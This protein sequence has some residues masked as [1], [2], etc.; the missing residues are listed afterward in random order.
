MSMGKMGLLGALSGLGEGLSIYGKSMFDDAIEEKRQARLQAIRDKEYARTR[1]DQEADR[2]AR[3][4]AT[5]QSAQMQI[6][7]ANTRQAELLEARASESALDRRSREDIASGSNATRF[8]IAGLDS[9]SDLMKNIKTETDAR[10]NQTLFYIDP[11]TRQKFPLTLGEPQSGV[12]IN[13]NTEMDLTIDT[14]NEMQ[15]RVFNDAL[16][17]EENKG[18]SEKYIFDMLL[19][20]QKFKDLGPR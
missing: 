17:L 6:D 11:E 12:N 2:D 3:I 4:A 8:A 10:G 7:A 20:D 18:Y 1:A 16:G 13:P 15:R 14:M 19:R 5:Q 9:S